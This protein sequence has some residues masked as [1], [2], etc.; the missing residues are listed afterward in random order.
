MFK[1]YIFLL[2]TALITYS[3]IGTE[4]TYAQST[5]N[6]II[7]AGKEQ[8]GTPY[9]WGGTTTSGFDCSGF[10]GYAFAQ[11]GISLPRTAAEQYKVGTS[12]SRNDLQPGDLVFFR[13]YNSGPS[14]NGI[15]IGNNQFIHSSSSQGV[16]ISSLGNSYWNPRYLGARRVISAAQSQPDSQVKAASMASHHNSVTVELN[17]TALS[18][19]QNPIIVNGSTLVPMRAIFESLGANVEWDGANKQINGVRNDQS[20]SLIIGQTSAQTNN[21]TISLNEPAQIINGRTIVPLRFISEALGAN[22]EWNSKERKV[23]INN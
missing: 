16:T 3:A 12:V 20:V 18:F 1:K 19:D 23:I 14:H 7:S 22:V 10:T 13:T 17:G 11:A 15:Y 9:R 2:L 4:T 8:I 5:V 6:Q 21:G